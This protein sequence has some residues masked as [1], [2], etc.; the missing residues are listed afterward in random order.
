MG[1]AVSP[2]VLHLGKQKTSEWQD[3]DSRQD[4]VLAGLSF[5]PL[6]HTETE[7]TGAF[8]GSWD[9]KNYMRMD[10]W[11]LARPADKRRLFCSDPRF[12]GLADSV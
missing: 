10:S 6:C 1:L 8:Y 12:Q 9:P 2:L 11:L 4:F 5:F 3:G 7:D